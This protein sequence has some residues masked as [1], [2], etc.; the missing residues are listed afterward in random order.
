MSGKRKDMRSVNEK[1]LDEA[2]KTA[3]WKEVLYQ[4]GSL[5]PTYRTNTGKKS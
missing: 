2:M 4:I 1:R 5:G 3:N